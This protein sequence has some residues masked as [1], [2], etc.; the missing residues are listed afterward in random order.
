MDAKID[1][2]LY[3]DIILD[4]LDTKSVEKT[5]GNLSVSPVKVRKVLITEGIWSSRTSLEIKH[6][7]NEKKTTAEIA[8]I[9]NTT[10]KAVQQYLPYSRGL[11]N[12]ENRSADAIKSAEYRRRIQIAKEHTIKKTIDLS[13]KEGWTEMSN[14]PEIIE[15]KEKA[16]VRQAAINEY[17][18]EQYPG[19]LCFRELPDGIMDF[20]KAKCQGEDIVRLHLELIHS[21]D[22]EDAHRQFLEENPQFVDQEQKEIEEQQRVL[23]SYGKLQYGP[24]ISRDIAVPEDMPLYALHYVIQKVFGWQNSHL[25]H[26][27]LPDDVFRKIIGGKVSNWMALVGVLLQSPMMDE[28]DR[29]WADD[30]EDGSFKTWLRKK[31]TG[32]YMSLNHGEGIMQSREDIAYVKKKCAKVVVSYERRK[33]GTERIFWAHIAQGNEDLSL[34]EQDKRF[35]IVRKEIISIDDLPVESLFQLF[36]TSPNQVLERLSIGEILVFRDRGLHDQIADSEDL[37]ESFEEF[38]DDDLRSEIDEI[39][40]SGQDAPWNQPFVAPCTDTLYYNYDYGDNW[41]V[42]ITGSLGCE[43]LVEEGRITQDEIDEALITIYSKYKPVCLAADGLPVLDDVGGISGY[44]RFLRGINQAKEKAY[45]KQIAKENQLSPEEYLDLIP[46]NWDYDDPDSL[47]WAK[48][49]G[50]SKR[51]PGRKTLL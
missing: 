18:V 16:K 23:K 25:H 12:S 31:Y 22:K 29:F 7:L 1:D 20:S 51:M 11:Y 24:T 5:A 37:C 49:L 32:P 48:G 34:S 50:W 14:I 40:A 9:L 6:Y 2:T 10:E 43:D 35:G 38:M 28:R 3:M 44:I 45:W 26:F 42:K 13:E 19:I 30:Y 27:E 15:Y 21:E 8:Q 39:L 33:D 46:D 47:D 36:E 17:H 4:Y 41:Y